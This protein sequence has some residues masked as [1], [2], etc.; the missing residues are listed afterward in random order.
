MVSNY[1]QSLE[2]KPK[3]EVKR[4]EVAALG[5]KLDEFYLL[6]PKKQ[7]QEAVN[8]FVL[9]KSEEKKVSGPFEDF[10]AQKAF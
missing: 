1:R 10:A 4:E 3:D 6:T 5:Q 8:D 9:E 7:T 2:Y